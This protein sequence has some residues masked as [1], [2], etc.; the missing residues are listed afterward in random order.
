MT[1]SSMFS[2]SVPSL[3]STKLRPIQHQMEFKLSILESKMKHYCSMLPLLDDGDFFSKFAIIY[4]DWDVG[5]ENFRKCLPS[6]C[7]LCF[8]RDVLS[9][10]ND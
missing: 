8:E 1:T 9:D 6:L 5:D 2:L 7:P 3:N 10:D 4:D